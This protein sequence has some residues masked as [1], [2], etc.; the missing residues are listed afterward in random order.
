MLRE[1]ADPHSDPVDKSEAKVLDIRAER[2]LEQIAAILVEI[3]LTA[4][5]DDSVPSD[6]Q[7][8]RVSNKAIG[9]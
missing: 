8:D 4:V 3:A 6:D 7:G 1:P 9:T 2:A 5:S